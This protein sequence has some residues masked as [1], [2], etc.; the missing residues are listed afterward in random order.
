M[1]LHDSTA[2]SDVVWSC[3]VSF[4]G[5][6]HGGGVVHNVDRLKRLRGGNERPRLRGESH[7]CASPSDTLLSRRAVE[8]A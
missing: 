1:R 5:G 3:R 2:S 6:E 4:A 8:S 7:G